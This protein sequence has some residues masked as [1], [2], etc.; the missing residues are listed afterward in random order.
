V[1]L[2]IDLGMLWMIRDHLALN[3][4]ML[5]WPIDAIHRWQAGG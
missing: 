2:A 3:V 5:L 4:L 1:E